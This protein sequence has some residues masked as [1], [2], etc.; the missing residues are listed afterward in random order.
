[1]GSGAT[2]PSISYTDQAGNTGNTATAQGWVTTAAINRCFP[3]ALA[4]GDTGVR[5][6]QSFNNNASHTSGAGPA[7]LEQIE[8]LAAEKLD[9]AKFVWVHAYNEKDMAIH[10]K[11][12][13]LGA[14]VEFDGLGPQSLDWHLASVRNMAAKKLLHRTLVS[15]DAGYYRPGEPDGGPFRPYAFL[16]TGFVPK[17]DAGWAKQLFVDNP[18]KAYG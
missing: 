16:Y 1:M 4:A 3:F 18:V 8:I 10:E 11:A 12:A 5:S 7:A 15:Q 9:L 2:A 6:I 14:W 17:L 13:K